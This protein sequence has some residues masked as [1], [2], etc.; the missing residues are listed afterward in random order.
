MNKKPNNNNQENRNQGNQ[1]NPAKI[2]VQTTAYKNTEIGVIPEEWEVKT[3]GDIGKVEMCKRVFNSQTQKSG[4]I[5][6]YKIG[7]FGKE[8]DA[9]ISE[10]LYL[11]YRKR[12]SFPK[13]GDILISASGTIGRT[14]VY[15][16]KPA[17]FQDSNIVWIGNS[18]E[19]IFNRY[20][21]YVLQVVDYNSEGSTIQR[22]YNSIIKN[23]K[24]ILPPLPEQ[25]AIATVLSDTDSLIQALEK[26]IAK[27][28]LIKKGAMQKLLNPINN[29]QL[30]MDNYQLSTANYPLKKGWITKTLGEVAELEMGQSPNSKFY[31]NFKLGLPLIQGNADIKNRVTIIRNYT[32]QIT[33]K[34]KIG[35][36]IMSVR[37]PVGE[38]AKATF[39][40]CIGRG[41]CAITF[42][43]E[44]LYH[45]LIYIEPEWAKLS[46]GSTFDSVNSDT[47][48]NL[49][50]T[51]PKSTEEQTRIAQI[52]S[53]M[54]AEIE[55]LQK[56]LAKYKQIKQ[57]LM[58]VLLTG[59]IRLV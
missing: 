10:E 28:Q 21:Y 3:L 53:D 55:A 56:K 1:E 44:Y 46:T 30:T 45:Y 54:D 5:P 24:F 7:T 36:I 2:K 41:V 50:L 14:I 48:R 16:G 9:Y 11:S 34:C 49:E 29:G 20:L 18:E 27:K 39:D 52:L 37:A 25:K 19:L 31:N 47:I 42:P 43:N 40:A 59:K 51:I 22:L 17:Y 4:S 32:S 15:D 13:K 35:D 6:F 33:K 8:P 38:I 58:Q 23:A 26:K 57:G 12:F